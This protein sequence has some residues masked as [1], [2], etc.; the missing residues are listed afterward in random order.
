MSINNFQDSKSFEEKCRDRFDSIYMIYFRNLR[1]IDVITDRQ[2][3]FKG[4]DVHLIFD[5][6]MW[7]IDEKTRA[8]DYNDILIEYISNNQTK[9]RG[10]IYENESTFL[11][12]LFPNNGF[13]L[14][15][16][17]KIKEWVADEQSSFWHSDYKDV[18]ADNVDPYGEKFRTISKVIPF[19][20]MENND[21]VFYK[22]LNVTGCF[23]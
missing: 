15:N 6:K 13:W 20:D 11:A 2:L 10:W 23:K 9:R 12:Y 17:Q 4:H 7:I 5:D 18:Y 21:L 8:R 1:K 19:S 22:I 16:T 3:Q 14:L